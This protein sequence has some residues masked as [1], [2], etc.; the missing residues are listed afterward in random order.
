MKK[1]IAIMIALIMV[2]MSGISV[3]ADENS[4]KANQEFPFTNHT[5]PDNGGA[6]Y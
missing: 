6:I 2:L 5:N 1:T 4:K 3:F